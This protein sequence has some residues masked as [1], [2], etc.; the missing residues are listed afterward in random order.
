VEEIFRKYFN[1]TLVYC[2]YEIEKRN[3]GSMAMQDVEGLLH[4]LSH[5]YHIFQ[6]CFLIVNSIF[7]ASSYD[8]ALY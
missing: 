1:P 4:I 5:I 7:Y 8:D 6:F 2:M 3:L